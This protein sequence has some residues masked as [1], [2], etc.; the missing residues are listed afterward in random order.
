MKGLVLTSTNSSN[1]LIFMLLGGS[2]GDAPIL[3][4]DGRHLLAARTWLPQVLLS[5]SAR[6]NQTK[7]S[8]RKLPGF[9]DHEER[10][11]VR[12]FTPP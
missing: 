7:N 11:Q 10:D 2:E 5:T 6:G 8:R 12:T 4:A 1:Q 3:T 9:V